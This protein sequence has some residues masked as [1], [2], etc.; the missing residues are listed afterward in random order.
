MD[1]CSEITKYNQYIL[2][3]VSQIKDFDIWYEQN[4]GKEFPKEWYNLV[5]TSKCNKNYED[6]SKTNN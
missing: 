2:Q 6:S 4:T 3:F 5:K 1:L